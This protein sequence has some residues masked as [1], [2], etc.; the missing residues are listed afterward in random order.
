[1]RI[2]LFFI[3]LVSLNTFGYEAHIKFG[4]NGPDKKKMSF[5]LKKGKMEDVSLWFSAKSNC[6]CT[7]ETYVN[8][9]AYN[10]TCH[11]PNGY[12]VMS[13]VNC[14]NNKGEKKSLY[15]FACINFYG[16]CE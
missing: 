12:R 1:M 3:F 8:G 15:M 16:W 11:L 9:E 7:A 13:T 6:K 14:N 10:I 5:K 2:I 4:P